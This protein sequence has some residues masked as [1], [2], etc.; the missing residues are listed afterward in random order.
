MMF[1]KNRQD[2]KN[3]CS[4]ICVIYW[5]E[6]FET[7]LTFPSVLHFFPFR[8]LYHPAEPASVAQGIRHKTVRQGKWV[9]ARVGKQK[10]DAYCTGAKKVGTWLFFSSVLHFFP[11][12]YLYLPF[13]F[14]IISY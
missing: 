4:K 2:K 3:Q 13:L 14:C 1:S 10:E 11:F 7:W 12:R 5:G 8:Y 6:R 9:Q